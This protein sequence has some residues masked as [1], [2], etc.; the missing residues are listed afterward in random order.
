MD[1]FS[2]SQNLKNRILAQVS[3]YE[4]R[5]VRVKLAGFGVAA[6]GS[7]GVLILGAES[8][9]GDASQSGFLQFASLFFSN[10]SAAMANFSDVMSSLIESFPVFSTA[11]LLGGIF[12]SIWSIAKLVKE[13]SIAREQYA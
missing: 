5:R 10:F 13:I 3:E 11:L 8:A 4:R 1:R 7:L 12:A 2:A 9:L 6:F